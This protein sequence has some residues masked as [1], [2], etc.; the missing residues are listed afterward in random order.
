MSGYF[1]RLLAVIY[2]PDYT[3]QR[4]KNQFLLGYSACNSAVRHVTQNLDNDYLRG[5]TD[6]CKYPLLIGHA[7]GYSF[8]DRILVQLIKKITIIP[9]VMMSAKYCRINLRTSIQSLLQV[10]ECKN[11]DQVDSVMLLVCHIHVYLTVIIMI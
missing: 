3:R 9:Q 8:C 2:I 11:V 5:P 10:T 6:I 7:D 1:P 4:G